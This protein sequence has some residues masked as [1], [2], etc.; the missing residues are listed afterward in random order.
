[1][2]YSISKRIADAITAYR[3]KDISATKKAHTPDAIRQASEETHKT[4]SGAYIGEAVYG[5]LDGVVTTFAVVAGVAGAKLSAGVVLIL[6]FANLV[7][8]GLSMGVGSYLSTKSKRQYEQSERERESWEIDN[9][10]EGEIHEIREIYRR[11]G[12][13]GEDL[14]KAVK[15]ITSNKEIWLETMMNEEL[16]I[17]SEDGHPFYNGLSTFIA[18]MLVGFVP[19]LF[20]VLA[21]AIPSL[22]PYS[23]IMSIVLT[24]V[25]LFAVGSLRVLVT[26]SNWF[27]SGIEM[28]LVGGAAALGSYLVG[29]FLQGLAR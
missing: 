8:D 29:Y 24:A 19:L 27:R 13:Q 15:I 22:A 21:L 23:F 25:T 7:G 9:Y 17:I 4:E 5:A 3:R 6:G 2:M 20:F 11:K 28:L 18:F 14:D 16:G 12:F 1:M 26:Q 10:P